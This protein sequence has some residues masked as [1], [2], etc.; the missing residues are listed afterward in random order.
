MYHNLEES[1]R[2]H[3]SNSDMMLDREE[4]KRSNKQIGGSMQEKVRAVWSGDKQNQL[5][6]QEWYL[7][8]AFPIKTT[9]ALLPTF[10]YFFF[11]A[12]I[13]MSDRFLNRTP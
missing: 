4:K 7:R 9:K 2:E 6:P 1:S 8:V 5:R 10:S 13:Q 11:S 3:H 12:H